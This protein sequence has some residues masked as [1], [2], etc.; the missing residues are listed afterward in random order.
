MNEAV[1]HYLLS[2]K[3]KRIGDIKWAHA[4]NNVNYL[5]QTLANPDVDFFE[6]DI[7]ISHNG[8]PIAAHYSNESDLT[9][10]NLL[11]NV[12]GFDKG[13]KL[14]F[15]EQKAILP[16]LRNLQ[17]NQLH[18][19]VI[20]NADILSTENAPRATISPEEFI[21]NCQEFYPNGLLSIGWRTNNDS[22]YTNEDIDKMLQLCRNIKVVT[23]PVRASIL[24]RSW[25]NVKKI[26]EKD[27]YTLTI[28]NSEPLDSNLKKWIDQ[29]TDPKKC[30]YDFTTSKHEAGTS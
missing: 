4:V 18:Q 25:E 26:L 15:K 22:N 10:E 29:N 27:G 11:N 5:E 14:D 12:K 16:C 19:P 7:S 2:N 17:A 6:V 20:L 8:E 28:W 23:F 24:P 21:N 1:R 9:F 3:I 13:I 30:F